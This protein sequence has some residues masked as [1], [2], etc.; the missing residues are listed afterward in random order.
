MLPTLKAVL[1]PL[2]SLAILVLGNGL[3][4]TLLTVRLYLENYSSIV[5]GVVSAAYFA[6]LLIGSFR[7]ERFVIRVGHIRAYT[8]FAA[9]MAVVTMLHGLLVSPWLWIILRLISG[10]CVA[11]LM[12]T[13]ESWI[14]GATNNQTR[15]RIF[16][17][18]L[19]A[20]Y[21][22]LALGQLLLNAS[23]PEGLILFCIV[24]ILCAL[25]IVPVSTTYFASP[26]L[27]E[28]APLNI[29]QLYKRSPSGVLGSFCA[30]MLLASI[31]GLMPLF[32]SEVRTSSSDV[33]MLMGLIIFGG[34]LGQ[35]PVGRLSDKFD[36]RSV[37]MTL[38]FITAGICLL[39]IGLAHYF[40]RAFVFSLV[41]F[42]SLAFSLYPLSISHASDQLSPSQMV[43]GMQSLFLA[44][45]AGST[46]G[47]LVGAGLMQI[48]D[49]IGLF[50]YFLVITGL[51][52]TFISWR[53]FSRPPVPEQ[54]DF[55]NTPPTMPVTLEP[56]S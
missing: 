55:S 29:K 11:G 7:I 50:I 45:A 23:D 52:G 47:P 5:I 9:I 6:G 34:M 26:S 4:L 32:I 17:I 46:L 20:I 43:G 44:F 25:S 51:L 12:I 36:R 41:V 42:G 22:A 2:V 15:G 33:A 54:Q 35:Y 19:T 38:S 28:P 30:G 18:Y 37:L 10:F 16:A 56:E 39:N 8:T 21:G 14:M 53:R 1:S 48:I 13:I 24:T 31:Y 3:L 40:P 49:P 27:E